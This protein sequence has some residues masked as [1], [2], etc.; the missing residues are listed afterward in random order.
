MPLRIHRLHFI[1][2]SLL[3]HH[4]DALVNPLNELVSVP[5]YRQLHNVK[6]AFRHIS[7]PE[8]G[9]GLA[10]LIINL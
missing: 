10:G 7:L 1:K 5:K 8:S 9:V 6:I 4:V 2:Q 3:H